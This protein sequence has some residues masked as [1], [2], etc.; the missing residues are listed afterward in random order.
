M[1]RIGCEK[2]GGLERGSEVAC[3]F[4]SANQSPSTV[5]THGSGTD[6]QRASEPGAKCGGSGRAVGEF[7]QKSMKHNEAQ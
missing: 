5:M 6:I 7:M 2:N 4:R 1:R 3:P